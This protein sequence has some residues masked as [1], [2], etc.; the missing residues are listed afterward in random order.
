[1]PGLGWWS[2]K[3]YTLSGSSLSP[4][5]QG[6][7]P[8]QARCRVPGK[9]VP[10]STQNGTNPARK[11]PNVLLHTLERHS[12][13]ENS[14][15]SPESNTKVSQ[16]IHVAERTAIL[17][18]LNQTWFTQESIHTLP[19]V[20]NAIHTQANTSSLS[21]MLIAIHKQECIHTLSLVLNAIHTQEIIHT[22]SL[23]LNAIH[24]QEKTSSPTLVLNAIRTQENSLACS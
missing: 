12:T 16:I 7:N 1:M 10:P 9:P 15:K 13:G 22:L 14:K 18:G 11:L 2:G 8:R 21:L 23:V 19:L 20:L 6:S 4:P 5:K 17:N 24:T 3:L